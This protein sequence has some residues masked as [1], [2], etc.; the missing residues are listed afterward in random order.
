MSTKKKP[1]G[2][3]KARIDLAELEKLAGL[4]CT[5]EEIGA[6]FGISQKTIQRRKQNARF[7]ELLERGRG[8]GKISLRR[9]QMQAA[10]A[11]N[12]TAQIWL[13][14]QILGQRDNLDANVTTTER[15]WSGTMEELLA[16][17]RQAQTQE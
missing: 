3:P 14:K 6:W 4:Q 11:G 1:T 15:K 17:Y 12:I 5:D 7:V 10:L 8:K 9:A 16:V 13:G 2:R